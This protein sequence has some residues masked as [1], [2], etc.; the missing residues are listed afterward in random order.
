MLLV[1]DLNHMK[2]ISTIYLV[3]PVTSIQIIINKFTI[4]WISVSLHALIQ[5]TL[6][7]PHMKTFHKAAIC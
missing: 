4:P 1:L 6:Y 3:N 5:T 2:T 7:Q